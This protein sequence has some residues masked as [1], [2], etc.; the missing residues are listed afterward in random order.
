VTRRERLFLALAWVP[1][2]VGGLLALVLTLGAV[3][4]PPL[5]VWLVGDSAGM[6]LTLG[7]ALSLLLVPVVL[8]AWR[9]RVQQ[10]RAVDAAY[11]SLANQRYEFLGRLDHELKNPLTAILGQLEN[12][13]A[14]EL[15]PKQR[16]GPAG[17]PGPNPPRSPLKSRGAP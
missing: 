5:V 8:G 14:G 16:R 10:Q 13:G 15:T 12:L 3:D 2:A 17:R 1:L 4:P 9:A 11:Q 7:L 6:F